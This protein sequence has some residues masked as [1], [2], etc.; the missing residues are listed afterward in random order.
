MKTTFDKF[1]NVS[2]MTLLTIVIMYFSFGITIAA[3]SIIPLLICIVGNTLF[4]YAAIV[5]DAD[6]IGNI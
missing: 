5:T 2:F 1:L 3:S 6:I 4:V